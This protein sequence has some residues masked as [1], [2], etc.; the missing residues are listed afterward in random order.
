MVIASSAQEI[1]RQLEVQNYM[2]NLELI[3]QDYCDPNAV[4]CYE[5]CQKKTE[6]TKYLVSSLATSWM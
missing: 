3:P 4:N 1:H 6:K 2:Q 5:D